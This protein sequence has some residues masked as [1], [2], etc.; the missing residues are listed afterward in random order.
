MSD[1]YEN[2]ANS[3]RQLRYSKSKHPTNPIFA[4]LNINSVRNKLRD[5]DDMVGES[6]EILTISET[7]LNASFP[8]GLFKLHR[9]CKPY[10]L[11]VSD[12]SGGLLTYV[13][14]EIPS[15]RLT[16][17]KLPADVQAIPVEINLRKRKWLHV[18]IYRPPSQNLAYFLNKL[19]DLL[20]FYLQLII[21]ML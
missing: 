8:D 16:D 2:N 21:I 9:F 20:D 6:V 14:T 17:F 5:V 3:V 18:A 11:D 12:V 7:K 4:Y 19:S 15:R 1:I 10:R 13:H